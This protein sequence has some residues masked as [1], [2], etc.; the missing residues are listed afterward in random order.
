MLGHPIIRRAPRI[1]LAIL[2]LLG[3]LTAS[4]PA[5]GRSGTEGLQGQ[6]DPALQGE[7]PTRTRSNHNTQIAVPGPSGVSV[8]TWSGDLFYPLSLLTIP[9]HGL[10]LSIDLSYNSSWHD[11][12]QHYGPGWQLSYNMFYVRHDTGDITVV[13]EDGRSDRFVK[14]NGA[15]LSPVDT[16]DTLVEYLPGKYVL[17]TKYGLDERRAEPGG[18]ASVR[19]RRQLER[20]HRSGRGC[21]PLRLRPGPL[22]DG[23]YSPARRVDHDHLHERGSHDAHRRI[24]RPLLRL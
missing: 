24:D 1:A 23:H 4:L 8:S 17:R 16:Y 19:C 14:S 9:G 3:L 15:F 7:E 11:Y 21:Y 13:W 20:H 18:T 6:P 12:G 5:A 10:P 2:C 22:F